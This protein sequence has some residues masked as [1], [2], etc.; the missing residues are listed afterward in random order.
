MHSP[1]LALVCTSLLLL[2]VS[3]LIADAEGPGPSAHARVEFKIQK[4][5][6]AP[7]YLFPPGHYVHSGSLE[8][9]SGGTKW[10]SSDG[11]DV[12]V[13][14][15]RDL[16]G[17]GVLFSVG[18]AGKHVVVEYDYRPTRVGVV[19]PVNTSDLGYLGS[20]LEQFVVERLTAWGFS[21]ARPEETQLALT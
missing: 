14:T 5:V 9:S 20:Y 6:D 12:R 16:Y 19:R 10:R 4:G 15:Y 13:R 1:K 17:R 18:D 11:G 3:P 7:T 8:V 21:V 2:V